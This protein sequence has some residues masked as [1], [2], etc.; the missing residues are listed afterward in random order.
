MGAKETPRGGKR[1]RRVEKWEV[2]TKPITC[3]SIIHIILNI[4][5][6]IS[7]CTLC[8]QI[9]LDEDDAKNIYIYK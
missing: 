2:S 6:S 3:I 9:H 8:I 4:Y 7:K 1:W 5:T